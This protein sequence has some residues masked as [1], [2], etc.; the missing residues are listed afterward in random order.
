MSRERVRQLRERAL[1]EIRNVLAGGT[2]SATLIAGG[3]VPG[4]RRR[5]NPGGRPRA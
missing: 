2:V 1:S 5:K 4:G 3:S